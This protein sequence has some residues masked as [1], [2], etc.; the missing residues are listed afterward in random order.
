VEDALHGQHVVDGSARH[1]QPAAVARHERQGRRRREQPP[2]PLQLALVDV[3][4]DK[5]AARRPCPQVVQRAAEPAAHVQHPPAVTD[6]RGRQDVLGQR[7]GR[8]H[9]ALR[10]VVGIVR[11][12]E[13]APVEVAQV[14]GRRPAPIELVD[15]RVDVGEVDDG[16]WRTLRAARNDRSAHGAE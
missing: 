2:G 15:L 8:P 4:P 7:R 11:P 1:R 5:A 14:L 12:V 16:H 3:Q 13:Q 9:V 10:A 6:P